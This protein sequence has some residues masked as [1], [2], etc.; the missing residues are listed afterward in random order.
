MLC[1]TM[2]QTMYTKVSQG[3]RHTQCLSPYHSLVP[4]SP[5]QRWIIGQWTRLQYDYNMTLEYTTRK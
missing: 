5:N 1:E 2:T 3:V 4:A